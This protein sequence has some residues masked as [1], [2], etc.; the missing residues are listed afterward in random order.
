MLL[1]LWLLWIDLLT[2]EDTTEVPLGPEEDPH[3]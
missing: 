3:G 1:F 2:A